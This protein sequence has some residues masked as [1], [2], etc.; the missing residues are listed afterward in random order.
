MVWISLL[1]RKQWQELVEKVIFQHFR[2][3][4]V[5]CFFSYYV[6]R[7][8]CFVFSC[9]LFGISGF[10]F[11]TSGFLFGISGFLFG[12]SGFLFGT[13]CFLFGTSGFPANFKASTSYFYLHRNDY[14]HFSQ[15]KPIR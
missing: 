9:F 4:H 14:F 7:F 11:G 8:I 10:L 6:L 12:I 3:F 15:V 2:F 1:V 13:S 5:F